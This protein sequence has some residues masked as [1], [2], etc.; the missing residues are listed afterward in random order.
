MCD[1]FGVQGRYRIFGKNSEGEIV[2]LNDDTVEKDGND[3]Y[4]YDKYICS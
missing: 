3:F 1:T 2:I 4:Y